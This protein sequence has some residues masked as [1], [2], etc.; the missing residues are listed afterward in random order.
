MQ[1]SRKSDR[2]NENLLIHNRRALFF[3]ATH[4][5]EKAIGG[6][7]FDCTAG[8]VITNRTAQCWWVVDTFMLI[9]EEG[10]GDASGEWGIR[11]FDWGSGVFVILVGGVVRRR[12]RWYIGI[13]GTG[14]I[15]VL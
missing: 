3:L 5:A 6:T 14:T 1:R 2:D 9:G 8:Q 7:V 10:S 13:V 12:R 11:C 4:Q 15:V